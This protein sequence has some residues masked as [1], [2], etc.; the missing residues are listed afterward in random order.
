MVASRPYHEE[1]PIHDF[2]IPSLTKDQL[3]AVEIYTSLL[4]VATI[5]DFYS[6]DTINMAKAL[7]AHRVPNEK[8]ILFEF[9]DK[10]VDS[11][12]LTP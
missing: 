1:F 11:W 8:D 10:I 2:A 7:I 9:I 5:I 4:R 12:G 6:A 3:D